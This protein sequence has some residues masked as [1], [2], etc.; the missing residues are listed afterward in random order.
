[1]KLKKLK[2]TVSSKEKTSDSDAGQFPIVGIGASAGG[3]EAL[4]QFLG[5]VPEN[6]GIAYVVIQHLDPTQ[7]GLLP[8]L[9]QRISKMKV[10]QVKDR[11]P[12]NPNCVYVIPPNTSMSILKGMLHL[13]KPIEVRGL[14]LPIDFFL[15]SLANDRKERGVG[16]ILSGMGS[17]GSIGLRAI[18]EKN[19]TVMVQDPVTAKFDSM[20]RN[21]I[22][23]VLVDIVA[24]ANK[25][26]AMLIDF[27]KHIPVIKS[28]LDI[29]VEDKSALEKIYIL[30]RTHTG[31]DFSLYKKNTVY[32]RIERRM[33]VHKIDKISSYVNF[34]Q[35]NP[36]EVN[37]LF[38][39][40][41]IG[42]TN[43]FRDTLVWEKLS[44][45]VIPNI[46]DNLQ[47]G[48][49]LRAWIP[50]CSTGEEAY[51]LAIVFKE[52]LEKINPQKGL[53]LQIFATDLD[54]EAIEIAR[55]GIFHANIATFVSP[56]RL[57]RFFIKTDDGYRINTEIREMVVFAKHNIIMHPPFTKIDF[58]SCRN[59]LIYMDIELQEKLLGLF[60]YS[61]N[62]EGI[63][64]LGSSET[65]RT[66]SHLFT[67]VDDKL[68]IY[69][70]SLTTLIPELFDFPASFSRTKPTNIENQIPAKSTLNIQTLADQMMLQHFSS[71]GVLVN[72]NGDIIYIS[73]RTGKY[74]EPAVGKANM[75]IFAMLREGLRNEFPGAF[76]KAILRKEAVVLRNIKVGT[77]GGMKTFNVN[78]QWI[79]KPEP[80][81]GMVM[82]IF[83]DVP[84]ITDIKLQAKKRVK[85]LNSIRQS[86]LEKELQNAR[87]E[88]QN[89][90][91][92]RQTAQEELKS[93]NEEFQSTNEELQSTNEELMTSKEEMQS[94]NEELQTVN[95][96]LQAKVDDFSR[97]NNDM[98]NLLNST[99]IATLFLDKELNIRRYTNQATKIFK[100]IKSDIGRP[101]TDLV[102][103]LIYPELAANALDVLRTLVFIQKQIPAKD[104][105]WFSIRIMPYRT[106]D[107]RIDGLVITFINL[108]DLKQVEVKLHETEQIHRLLLNSSS[109]VVIRLSTDWKILEFNPEAENFFGKKHQDAVNQNY[110]KMFVPEPVRKKTEKEFNKLLNK[111]LDCKFKMQVIAAGGNMPFVEW[112]VNVLLNNLKMST[113]MIIIIK[114]ITKP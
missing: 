102:S 31:N 92:E 96:E 55:K 42:V 100:L 67:P 36:K 70:R 71:A 54:N 30:L 83:T 74:L 73:G 13:S 84:E 23:S 21:A 41:M 78:I 62:P 24:P 8:E 93:T 5:N 7:K 59:L 105:R 35:E 61:I 86:E 63:M 9:L 77:N 17:D 11:M 19:G 39:E 28:D 101:F 58:L 91:D 95:A 113:G 79:D 43:F 33:S 20:P 32:R 104:G 76:R 27:L 88:I 4:E 3:L 10:F 57:N 85:T 56:N 109:D 60:Y 26:P 111:R 18:K 97:V 51:S 15:R 65:L 94:L 40:L 1:M 107:D 81:N 34:L 90:L 25:L 106:F 53:S 12:V 66:Q 37:I 49:V 64:L 29:E 72:E 69:K 46:I 38:K 47:A 98:K 22:D 52:V 110:F 44:E 6:S 112:S 14:R 89:T 82:I 2:T 16:V 80:L 75:N 99:D 114:K 50:G 108:S 103:D 68:K 45:T 87:E 48:S